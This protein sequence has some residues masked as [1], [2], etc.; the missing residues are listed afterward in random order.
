[1]RYRLRTLLL[2]LAVLPP[3]LAGGWFVNRAIRAAT[4]EEDDNSF[5]TR[6]PPSWE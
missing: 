5:L 3:A 1:M 6:Y 2:L 4:V